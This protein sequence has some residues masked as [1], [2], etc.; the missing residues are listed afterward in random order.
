MDYETGAMYGYQSPYHIP[1]PA[2]PL[3]AP[4]SDYCPSPYPTSSG[5]STGWSPPEAALTGLD[6]FPTLSLAPDHGPPTWSV[7]GDIVAYRCSVHPTGAALGG[8][9]KPDPEA[10]LRELIVSAQEWWADKVATDASLNVAENPLRLRDT[11]SAD[12]LT[13]GR[14]E[15]GHVAAPQVLPAYEPT[16]GT[17]TSTTQR[18]D[19]LWDGELGELTGPTTDWLNFPDSQRYLEDTHISTAGPSQL[20]DSSPSLIFLPLGADTGFEDGASYWLPDAFSRELC[21]GWQADDQNQSFCGGNG[22]W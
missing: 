20:A 15:G 17:E 9:P 7:E 10:G 5:S 3:S 18:T 19:L 2:T 6:V 22:V 14:F 4:A 1:S 13:V 12:Y 11:L 21:G 8:M 16:R